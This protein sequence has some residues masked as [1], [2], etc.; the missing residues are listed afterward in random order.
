MKIVVSILVLLCVSGSTLAT[1]DKQP[2]YSILW[3]SF[4]SVSMY[5]DYAVVTTE[6]G[7]VVLAY[8][9]SFKSYSPVNYLFLDTEPISQKRNGSVLAVRSSANI[10]YFIDISGLPTLILFGEA[11]IGYPFHDYACYG[12]DIYIANGFRGLWR[13]TM[14]NYGTLRLADS[15]NIGIHYTRVGIYGTELYALDDYNG[16]LR[17]Q[18]TGISFGEF[19]NYL[20]VPNRVTSF[21]RVDQ[22]LA[23]ALDRPMMML[24]QL[25]DSQSEITD[26]FDLFFPGDQIYGIDTLIIAVNAEFNIAEMVN[27][28]TGE[29]YQFELDQAPDSSMGGEAIRWQNEDHLIFPSADG[30]LGL[31]NLEQI[32]TSP[33]PVPYFNRPGPIMDLAMWQGRLYTS[34]LGNPV[35]IFYLSEDG[36]PVDRETQYPGFP[37]TQAMSQD[38]DFLAIMY[39]RLSLTIVMR[40]SPYQMQLE[41][42]IYVGPDVEGIVFNDQPINSLRSLFT[43][44]PSRVNGYTLDDT[45]LVTPVIDISMINRVYDIEF[46]DSLLFIST[47]KNKVDIYRVFSDFG[48]SYQGNFG[49]PGTGL[50]LN[51]HHG[52]LLVMAGTSVMIIDPNLLG[53][54][55]PPSVMVP[56]IIEDSYV[57]GDLL[58][59]VGEQGFAVIDLTRNPPR[60]LDTGTRGGHIVSLQNG[61]VAISN[62][63][64]VHLF[65]TRDVITDVNDPVNGLPEAYTLDQNYPNPFNPSTTIRFTL[66]ERA[67]VS[68]ELFNILGQKVIDLVDTEL[69]AGEHRVIWMG[70]NDAGKK[71]ASGVYLYRLRT[72]D[73]TASRKMILL[74]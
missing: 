28:R 57:D 67:K 43:H 22:T 3:S 52:M 1:I 61:I 36:Q 19:K 46:I 4:S 23:M 39:P 16:I 33:E 51:R 58:A 54:I 31:Y 10:I 30:G 48:I 62:G 20:Y 37:S 66:P 53:Q 9:S 72:D 17:Y 27:T 29:Q 56:F 50:D 41:T 7:I 25:S 15:S 21:E 49:L 71:V 12:Q 13:Y 38:G 40:L 34:G 64:V 47:G 60:I 45:G 70:T 2:E 68:L 73:Y 35:D 55:T 44:T 26:T 24:G 65:D 59:V 32:K 63:N 11:D 42:A 14:V 74:K 5:D 69:P 6:E 8:D 18:L